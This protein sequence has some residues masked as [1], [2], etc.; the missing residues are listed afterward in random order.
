MKQNKEERHQ[1][2]ILEEWR[3]TQEELAVDKGPPSGPVG[4]RLSFGV[5]PL[6]EQQSPREGQSA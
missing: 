2:S 6:E 4:H 5:C 3:R 1:K